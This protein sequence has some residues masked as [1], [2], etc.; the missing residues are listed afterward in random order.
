MKLFPPPLT[1]TSTPTIHLTQREF[2]I[3]QLLAQGL[4]NKEIATAL[5][6]SDKTVGTH[7]KALFGKLDVH[8]RVMAIRIGQ[9]LGLINSDEEPRL[10]QEGN[11]SNSAKIPHLG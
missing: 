8:N 6:L 4:S 3:L 2:Q 10:E 1:T 9:N 5:C 7:M 11:D